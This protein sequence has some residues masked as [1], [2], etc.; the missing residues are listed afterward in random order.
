MTDPAA[1]TE[2][3]A[4]AIL[5]S[6]SAGQ[7]PAPLLDCGACRE[8]SILDATVRAMRAIDQR[9]TDA[10]KQ[11]LV[12]CWGGIGLTIG[13]YDGQPIIRI[14]TLIEPDTAK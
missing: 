3:L 6:Y 12:R 1:R 4:R 14:C 2:E 11:D 7:L 8:E 10:I 9:L 5:L 13:H